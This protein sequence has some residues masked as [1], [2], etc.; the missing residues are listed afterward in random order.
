MGDID[1]VSSNAR[2]KRLA[3]QVRLYT[4]L[5][6]RISKCILNKL[7]KQFYT[8]NPTRTEKI[9]HVVFNLMKEALS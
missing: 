6:D 8:R 5:Q 1:K 2:L 9:I 3:I 4:E 7:D